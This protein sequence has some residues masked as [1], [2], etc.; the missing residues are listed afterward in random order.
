[1]RH[2]PTPQHTRVLPRS[3][4]SL[5]MCTLVFA[6]GCG[7]T[8]VVTDPIQGAFSAAGPLLNSVSSAVPGLSQAQSALGVGSLLGLAKGKMP[9]NQFSQVTSALPGSEGLVEHAV[10]QGLPAGVGRLADVTAFLSKSGIS[11]GQVAQMI[12][13]LNNAVSSKVSPEVASAFMSAQW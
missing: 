7:K 4:A 6:A 1:M 3:I 13:V 10:K 5:V 12:P 11:S 8:A 2:R 9:A